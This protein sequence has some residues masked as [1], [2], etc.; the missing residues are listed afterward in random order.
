M[1]KGVPALGH[2]DR[3]VGTVLTTAAEVEAP[4][5]AETEEGEGEADAAAPAADTE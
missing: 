4:A 1:P 5:A 2:P 3:P